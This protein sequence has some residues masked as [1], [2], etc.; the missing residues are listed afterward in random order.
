[1]SNARLVTLHE[2]STLPRALFEEFSQKARAA[3]FGQTAALTRLMRRY[4]AHG[5]DDGQPELAAPPTQRDGRSIPEA[6][7]HRLRSELGQLER[8]LAHPR[9]GDDQQQ[10]RNRIAELRTQLE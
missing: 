3:G 6:D 9:H 7:R 2:S 1:M 10:I 4:L 5:F 8:Q